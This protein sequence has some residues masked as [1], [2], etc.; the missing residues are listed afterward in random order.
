MKNLLRNNSNN[1]SKISSITKIIIST[2]LKE[3]KLIIN[4]MEIIIKLVNIITDLGLKVNSVIVP[5]FE[6]ST[7]DFL[8]I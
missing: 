8:Y 5:D 1:N 7:F 3:M 4:N 2:K 6:I